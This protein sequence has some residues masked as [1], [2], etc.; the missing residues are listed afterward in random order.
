[1]PLGPLEIAL[2]VILF[3]I[4]FKPKLLSDFGRSLG[5][6]VREYRESVREE[7]H[8]SDIY[9]VAEALG[10]DVEDRSEDEIVEE[11]RKKLK[12]TQ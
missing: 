5:R 8:S 11:I 10:I 6:L 7:K 12:S 9:K 4:F 2:L 1:M 3:I